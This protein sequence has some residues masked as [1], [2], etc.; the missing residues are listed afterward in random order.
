M[1]IERKWLL[2]EFPHV[3]YN[4]QYI[5]HQSYV[6]ATKDA[7]LRIRSCAT[8]FGKFKSPYKLTYKNDGDLSR[9]ENEI[10]INLDQYIKL[11]N[12]IPQEYEAI[13]KVFQTYEWGDRTV[14]VSFVDG[15]W[16][17]AEVEFDSEEE[18]LAYE[19]PWP[20][21]IIKE[22]TYNKEYKMK[23]YWNNTRGKK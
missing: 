21:L 4:G 20:D 10:E 14:E 15:K 13:K 17:Y 12:C 7:E 6:V 19:F 8:M 9:I 16:Y 1:E 2:K 11:K 23:N 5:V 22:V 3:P 18:A